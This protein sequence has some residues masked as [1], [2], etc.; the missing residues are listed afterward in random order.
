MSKKLIPLSDTNYQAVLPIRNELR[1]FFLNDKFMSE[2]DHDYWY[3]TYRTNDETHFYLISYYG[4][5]VGT[6][7][8]HE[9]KNYNRLENIA[10]L[11]NYQGKG[12]MT[13]AIKKAMEKHK[14]KKGWRL[15]VLHGNKKAISLYKK[16][17]FKIMRDGNIMMQY[18]TD[19]PSSTSK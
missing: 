16:L 2:S 6:I 4:I 18:E 17:G 19:K 12:L 9:D 8:V 11:N 5:A 14:P 10:V 7:C 15:E 3:S 1:K 13:W